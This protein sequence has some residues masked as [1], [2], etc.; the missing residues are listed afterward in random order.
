MQTTRSLRSG[1][2]A[3]GVLAVGVLA[4][5]MVLSGC[6]SSTS[7]NGD[8]MFI[9][10]Q[11]LSTNNTTL[12]LTVV[13]GEPPYTWWVEDPTLGELSGVTPEQPTEARTAN[14]RASATAAPG[15]VNTV[16]VRDGR[17]DPNGHPEGSWTASALL[18]VE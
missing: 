3:L 4:G 8:E 16:W 9:E 17:G 18:V 7:L 10:V 13:G 11:T 1:L 2:A 6:E 5:G 12:A 15:S 14:Y